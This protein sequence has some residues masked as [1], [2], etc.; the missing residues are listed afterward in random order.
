LQNDG[1]PKNGR[2]D[3]AIARGAMPKAKKDTWQHRSAAARSRSKRDVAIAP[4]SKNSN[5]VDAQNNITNPKKHTQRH[6]NRD[7]EIH[8]PSHPTP[9]QIP[10]CIPTVQHLTLSS[11]PSTDVISRLLSVL[12]GLCGKISDGDSVADAVGQQS[13]HQV[14][15]EGK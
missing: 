8:I 3:C 12:R 11:I 14:G 9:C 2:A 13:G 6:R 1:D 15:E 7:E 5:N 4:R 10:S